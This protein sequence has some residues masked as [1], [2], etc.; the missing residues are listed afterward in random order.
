MIPG[1][2]AKDALRNLGL[3]PR[4]RKLHTNDT[5]AFETARQRWRA[6]LIASSGYCAFSPG[7]GSE[8]F[9]SVG[10]SWI[11]SNSISKISVALGPISGLPGREP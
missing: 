10:F 9:P 3:E 1:W 7:F 5:A 2:A 4:N 8:V 6:V 11:E